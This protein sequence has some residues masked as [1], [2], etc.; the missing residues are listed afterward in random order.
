[1]KCSYKK[2]KNVK[3]TT[4]SANNTKIRSAKIQFEERKAF[5]EFNLGVGLVVTT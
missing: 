5:N 2:K 4:E 3:I 1:M